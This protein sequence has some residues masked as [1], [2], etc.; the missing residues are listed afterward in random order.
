MMREGFKV[1]PMSRNHHTAEKMR[2]TPNGVAVCESVNQDSKLV[3]A[4]AIPKNLGGLAAPASSTGENVRALMR[5]SIYTASHGCRRRFREIRDIA[6]PL[7]VA[8]G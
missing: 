3:N 8:I 6:L 4:P 7:F 1:E 2:E 5:V